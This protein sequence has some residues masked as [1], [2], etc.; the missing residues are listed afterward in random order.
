MNSSKI[1]SKIENIDN[2]ERIGKSKSMHN[3]SSQ[4]K[5]S[6]MFENDSIWVYKSSNI[7]NRINEN[8]NKNRN[9]S[10]C[11]VAK[12]SEDDYIQMRRR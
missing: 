9:M 2:P 12:S 1:S 10:N 5:K 3:N 4:V 7:M 8:K 6:R 11:S